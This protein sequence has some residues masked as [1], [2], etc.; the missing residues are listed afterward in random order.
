NADTIV[1]YNATPADL[2]SGM[3][4]TH[5]MTVA[6]NGDLTLNGWGSTG[7]GLLLV[8]GKLTYDTAAS[9][10]GII[11]VIGKGSMDSSQT[12]SNTQIQGAVLLARTLDAAGMPMTPS[13]VPAFTATSGFDFSAI[14]NPTTNAIQYSSC[15]AGFA[16]QPLTYKVLSFREIP[17]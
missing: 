2:P 3:S 17:Q 9:W 4:P 11:L 1:N 12:G 14:A 10:N 8:T 7:Y 5:P 16:Q 13:S 15:Y 6:I